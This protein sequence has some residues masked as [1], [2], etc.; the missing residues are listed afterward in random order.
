MGSASVGTSQW[1]SFATQNASFSALSYP[2]ANS[3]ILDCGSPIHICN[4]ANRFDQSTFQKLDQVDPVLTGDSC[5]YM[6]GYGNV[7]VNINTPNGQHLF[8]LKK[9]AFIPGFHTNVISHRKLRQ[10]GYHWDDINL[11]VQRADTSETVFYV[12]EISE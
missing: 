9:V 6:E 11:S 3:F 4:D 5:S 12:E 10:A 2:L 7:Q 8:L 1:T